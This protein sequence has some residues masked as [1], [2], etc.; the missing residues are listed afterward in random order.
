[1]VAD[2]RFNGLAGALALGL[3]LMSMATNAHHS[4]AMYD[5]HRKLTIDGVVTRYEWANPHVYIYLQPATGAAVEWEVEGSPP[6]I[7]HSLGWSQDTLHVGDRV[8]ITGTATRDPARHGLLPSLIRR[9]DRVLFD[10]SKEQD[11]LVNATAVASVSAR[12]LD[13]VWATAFNKPV[14]EQLDD[15][16]LPLTGEA[17]S[18]LKHFDERDTHPNA[19]CVPYPAPALMVTPDLKRIRTS[20]NT[21]IIDGEFDGAQR[22]IHLDA[23]SHSGAPESIQGDSIGHWEA[24]SLVIDT[25]HFAF[26]PLGTSYGVPSSTRKHLLERL[27][28]DPD[29]KHLTYH[30][31]LTDPQYLTRTVSG[32]VQWVY[33]PEQV[34]EPPRCDPQNASRFLQ[35]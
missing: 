28:L 25:D 29:G 16:M 13:G 17:K 7:L 4:G 31:E 23:D 24:S 10:R 32:D 5:E 22:V 18:I 20:G 34:Y 35:R 26:H 8:S 19:Q 2:G 11:Q 30:F 33:R 21:I 14:I 27:T 1:M 6:S 15:G 9:G 3:M 12:G